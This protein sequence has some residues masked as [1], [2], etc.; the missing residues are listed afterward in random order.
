MGR[1]TPSRSGALQDADRLALRLGSGFKLSAPTP[2]SC[3]ASVCLCGKWEGALPY[4]VF[5]GERMSKI[6]AF[7]GCRVL[8]PP[9][10]H[11]RWYPLLGL[12]WALVSAGQEAGGSGRPEDRAPREVP[13]FHWLGGDTSWGPTTTEGPGLTET[14]SSPSCLLLCPPWTP[15]L[16]FL[17]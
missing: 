7:V 17:V 13:G 6:Q 9:P 14:P 2:Q 16:A 15:P 10:C 3:W 5:E 4:L 12:W 11:H 1:R 8:P